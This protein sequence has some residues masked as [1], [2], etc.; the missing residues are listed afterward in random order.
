M[1]DLSG[2]KKFRDFSSSVYKC[3]QWTKVFVG[4]PCVHVITLYPGIGISFNLSGVGN[5][6]VNISNIHWIYLVF[7]YMLSPC[8]M[9]W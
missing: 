4:I 6:P 2:S 1:K 7:E 9:E 5:N 3:M 8:T